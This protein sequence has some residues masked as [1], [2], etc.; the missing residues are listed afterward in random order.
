[1]ESAFLQYGLEVE[2]LFVMSNG[3]IQAILVGELH[4]MCDVNPENF[5]NDCHSKFGG[6][7]GT[8]ST[9][10]TVHKAWVFLMESIFSNGSVSQTMTCCLLVSEIP[11]TMLHA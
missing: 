5:P 7:I 6:P 10:T 8:V 11:I 4:T 2:K 3:T 9:F 1:M